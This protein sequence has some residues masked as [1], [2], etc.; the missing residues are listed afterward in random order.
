MTKIPPFLNPGDTIGIT[1]PAGYMPLKNVEHCVETL[2]SWGY[3]TITGNTVGFDSDNY[4]SAPDNERLEELQMMLDNENINAIL[5]GRGG[6]GMGRIIDGINFEKFIKNPKWLIGYSDITILH[7]HLSSKIKVASLH[8]PMASAFSEPEGRIYIRNLK[9]ILEGGRVEYQSEPHIYNIGGEASGRL[10]GGNLALLAHV[11]GTPSE[12]S[13]KD[14]ILFIEDV[15]EYIYNIDRMLYQLERS[16]KLKDIAGLI[17]GSFTDIKDTDRPFGLSVPEVINQI[18][19][20]IGC[21]VCFNFPVGHTFKNVALKIGGLYKL[22]VDQSGSKL[23]NL[24]PTL[25]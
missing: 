14:K 19:K 17:I 8:A 10:I 13:T 20:D 24:R 11:I 21:P 9:N 16:G 12:Y 3:K 25:S 4:F 7:C 6:Y 5:F 22:T 2:H 1:C 23:I 18:S 15:G